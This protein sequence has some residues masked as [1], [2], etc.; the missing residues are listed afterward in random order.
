[1]TTMSDDPKLPEQTAIGWALFDAADFAGAAQRFDLALQN[2]PTDVEALRGRARLHLMQNEIGTAIILLEHAL[3]VLQTGEDVAAP[4]DAEQR[5]RRDLAWAYYRLNRFDLAAE[6]FAALGE[7]ARAQKLAAFDQRAP[8][9]RRGSVDSTVLPLVARDPVPFV[10]LTLGNR[11]HLFVVDTG[12]GELT[13]DVRLLDELGLPR[14]GVQPSRTAASDRHVAVHHTIVPRV[15]LGDIVLEDV[16]AEAEDIQSRA[17]QIS[18]FI[19]FNLLA[20]FCT[21]LDVPEGVLILEPPGARTIPDHAQPTPFWLLDDHVLLVPGALDGREHLFAVATG[22]AGAALSAPPTTFTQSGIALETG[23]PFH[24]VSGAGTHEVTL[25][26]VDELRVGPL[27]LH[28]VEALV[29]LFS[30]SLEWRYG[31]RIGGLVGHDALRT[32]R[33]TLDLATQALWFEHGA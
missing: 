19:G 29:G 1:M 4:A 26:R 12:T 13:I 22:F 6:Q 11:D 32:T 21:T 15:R 33:W 27:T 9:R 24:G 17:P 23:M 28:D 16:P 8:Y 25:L 18:G 7:M 14:F 31:F 10:V 5:A 3:A 30:P 20:Q 2:D